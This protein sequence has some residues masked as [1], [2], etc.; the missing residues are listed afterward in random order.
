MLAL[1][2]LKLVNWY[3]MKPRRRSNKHDAVEAHS[4]IDNSTVK[5]FLS[6][7]HLIDKL[8]AGRFYP[9][10]FVNCVQDVLYAVDKDL[11]VETFCSLFINQL[12][13]AQESLISE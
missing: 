12:C 6:K 5:R 11:W 10:V 3:N 4:C 1:S 2:H 8:P 9:K 13:L 7:T